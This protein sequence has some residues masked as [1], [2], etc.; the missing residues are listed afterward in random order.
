VLDGVA[1]R[2]A[3]I[4]RSAFHYIRRGSFAGWTPLGIVAVPP[5]SS[6]LSSRAS[7][8]LGRG[9]ARRFLMPQRAATLLPGRHPIVRFRLTRATHQGRP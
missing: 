2:S 3:S 1:A 7:L 6:S 5:S 9:V 4:E 8:R